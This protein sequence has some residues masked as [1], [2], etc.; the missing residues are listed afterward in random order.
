VDASPTRR[1]GGSGLGLAISKKLCE[2]MGGQMW[3]ESRGLGCGTCF[4][5]SIACRT[6]PHAHQQQQSPYSLS[7]RPA[8]P[9]SGRSLSVSVPPK[10]RRSLPNP[11]PQIKPN[12][13]ACLH[14][15]C[16]K[17]RRIVFVG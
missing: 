8:T 5:W 12:T 7:G 3:A 9:P 16:T 14:R 15:R 10:A 4:R 13:L 11:N 1:Y 6:P 17:A 2:A